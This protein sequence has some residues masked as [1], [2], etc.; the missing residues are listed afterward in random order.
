MG[1]LE[2]RNE[3]DGLNQWQGRTAKTDQ[4]D[5]LSKTSGGADLGGAEDDDS[6]EELAA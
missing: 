2:Q 6:R 4:R 1:R 5:G 3:G